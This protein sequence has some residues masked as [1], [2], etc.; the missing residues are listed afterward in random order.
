MIYYYFLFLLLFLFQQNLL[1]HDYTCDS[2]TYC[3]E[4]GICEKGFYK[5]S[6]SCSSTKKCQ[7]EPFGGKCLCDE[8]VG[9]FYCNYNGT[10]FVDVQNRSN[11]SFSGFGASLEQV[12]SPSF[13]VLL[14]YMLLLSWKQWRLILL[15][16]DRFLWRTFSN[17]FFFVFLI[18]LTLQYSFF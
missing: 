10:S 3:S 12:L 15:F 9:K 7:K 8:A 17:D 4:H 2:G 16:R 1:K 6:R 11:D 13:F 14:V 5:K 18:W